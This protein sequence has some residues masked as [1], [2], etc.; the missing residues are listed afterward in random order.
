[1]GLKLETYRTGPKEIVCERVID[2]ITSNEP[3]FREGRENTCFYSN[4][5]MISLPVAL[6]LIIYVTAC[7][8][9]LCRSQ[10]GFPLSLYESSAMYTYSVL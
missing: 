7:A 2:V 8:A 5:D 9:F 10:V 3:H 6:P 4:T 1:M